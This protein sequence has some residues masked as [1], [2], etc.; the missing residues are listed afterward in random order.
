MATFMAVN[1]R[2]V[3]WDEDEAVIEE[4][5]VVKAPVLPVAQPEREFWE[6]PPPTPSKTKKGTKT[7]D[8]FPSERQYMRGFY[9]ERSRSGWSQG[10]CVD[11]K[12]HMASDLS[13]FQIVGF[14]STL[15]K[16]DLYVEDQDVDLEEDQDGVLSPFVPQREVSIIP[17]FT[18]FSKRRSYYQGG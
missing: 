15:R 4:E 3:N 7:R 10:D 12:N 2:V 17:K 6:T 18:V 16:K 5:P 1:K 11:L 8:F 14:I 13:I 9:E